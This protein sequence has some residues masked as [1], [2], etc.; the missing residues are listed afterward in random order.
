MPDMQQRADTRLL[1]IPG[2][3]PDLFAPPKGCGFAARCSYCMEV[4]LEHDPG[5]TAVADG[6][7]A[8]CWLLDERA[9][10]RVLPPV[11][12]DRQLITPEIEDYI[13]KQ[14]GGTQDGR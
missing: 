4:C 13:H 8:R 11:G 1:S 14:T 6:H 12:R 9:G 5:E 2:S 7:V 3:P 10:N